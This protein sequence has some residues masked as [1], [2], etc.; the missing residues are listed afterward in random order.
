MVSGRVRSELSCRQRDRRSTFDVQPLGEGDTRGTGGGGATETAA[1]MGTGTTTRPRLRT[2]GR[3]T[4]WDVFLNKTRTSDEDVGAKCGLE[5]GSRRRQSSLDSLL[6]SCSW[7]GRWQRAE[8]GQQF[9]AHARTV[10]C[11]TAWYLLWHWQGQQGRMELDECTSPPLDAACGGCWRRWRRAAHY[12]PLPPGVRL[13]R[14]RRTGHLISWRSLF[15][16]SLA[17]VI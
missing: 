1:G 11:W 10:W 4:E 16:S 15:C 9:R 14:A 5:S 6:P 8:S 3:A 13:L 17:E 12:A 7:P 2:G